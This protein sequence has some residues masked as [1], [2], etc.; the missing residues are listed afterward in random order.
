LYDLIYVS[1]KEEQTM[2]KDPKLSAAGK[3]GYEN[4]KEQLQ[5]ARQQK[6]AELQAEYA[7]N[8]NI[9][10]TCN[11]VLPFEKRR[12]RF[13]S[14]SCSATFNNK[15]VARNPAGKGFFT[16]GP[17]YVKRLTAEEEGRLCA[18]CGE[19]FPRDFNKYCD[20]CIAQGVNNVKVPHLADMKTDATRRTYLLRTREHRCVIC[21]YSEWTGQPIPLEVDHADGN[22]DN[23]T[24]ENLR[25]LC[26]NCHAQTETYKGKGKH[27]G[28][29]SRRKVMR[30]KRYK[31]GQSY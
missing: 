29:D 13:C 17:D 2:S 1:S 18:H 11:Q 12:N 7:A 4:A 15:G 23:N 14:Q 8:P 27:F 6:L 28:H 3:R 26:P 21:G 19:R 31:N 9:C 30:R 25:L 10:P 5:A 22:P 16:P 20:E 24:E